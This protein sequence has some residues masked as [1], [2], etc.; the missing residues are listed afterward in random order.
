MI[1]D[2][3]HLHIFVV[4]SSYSSTSIPR[5]RLDL[6]LHATWFECNVVDESSKKNQNS[7]R[8]YSEF[9]LLLDQTNP[10]ESD[11]KSEEFIFYYPELTCLQSFLPIRHRM[12]PGGY[13]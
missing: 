9:W 3:L 13:C 2:R 10:S 4:S 7:V 1:P 12:I 11:R 6:L 8:V 5:R